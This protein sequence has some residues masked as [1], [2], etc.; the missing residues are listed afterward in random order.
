MNN[1]HYRLKYKTKNNFRRILERIK[2]PWPLYKRVGGISAVINKPDGTKID[3]G[4]ISDT[5]INRNGY[6]DE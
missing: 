6:I 3:L 4:T 5:Y 1:T 2:H